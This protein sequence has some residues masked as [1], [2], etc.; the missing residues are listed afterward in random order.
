MRTRNGEEPLCQSILVSPF[1]KNKSNRIKKNQKCF[2]PKETILM[3]TRNILALCG[4]Y[5][6]KEKD[7]L[8]CEMKY[9]K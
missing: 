6:N 7:K 2:I 4:Q 8:I 3:K 9:V 1:I 5:K